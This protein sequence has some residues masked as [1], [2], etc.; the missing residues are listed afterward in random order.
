MENT[1]FVCEANFYET[2][3]NTF[4]YFE[5]YFFV[6]VLSFVISRSNKGYISSKI[7]SK[8]KK[9]LFYIGKKYF[10][11]LESL[12]V[13]QFVF[14]KLNGD[15]NLFQYQIGKNIFEI[16]LK[17]FRVSTPVDRSIAD[18]D[19]QEDLPKNGENSVVE[20]LCLDIGSELLH[21]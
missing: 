4:N 2:V 8:S 16:G 9:K 15:S 7:F 21:L 19:F 3:F 12:S 1:V 13:S 10:N 5:N 20:D 17:Y 14:F 11:Y 18:P 6:D